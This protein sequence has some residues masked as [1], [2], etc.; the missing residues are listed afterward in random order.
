MFILPVFVG[1][2]Y[3]LNTIQVSVMNQQGQILVNQSVSNDLHAVFSVVSPYGSNVQVAIEA[4]TGSAA[5][6]EALFTT[7]QWYVALAHPG[8]AAVCFLSGFAIPVKNMPEWMQWLTVINPA[9]WYLVIVKGVFLKGMGVTEVFWN[10]IPL[11][12][13]ALTTLTAAGVMFRRRMA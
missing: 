11:V 13:T 7:Y 12:L 8:Y 2:D 9:R 3:H 5:F 1:I 6:A 10:C 4:C